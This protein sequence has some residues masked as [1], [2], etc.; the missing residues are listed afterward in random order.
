MKLLVMKPSAEKPIDR[1]WQAQLR[2]WRCLV[3]ACARKAGRR[4]VHALRVVTLRLLAYELEPR[5][6]ARK[7][8]VERLVQDWF[9]ETTRIRRA[10]GDVR[11]LD[12]FRACAANL[13]AGLE[14]PDA[15]HHPVSRA[16]LR[17]LNKLDEKLRERR[18][19][20]G[21]RLAYWI[22]KKQAHLMEL[23][24][25]M[26]A[27]MCVA[28]QMDAEGSLAAEVAALVEDSA[29]LDASS[30]HALRKRVKRIRYI[31]EAAGRDRPAARRILQIVRSVQTA[32]GTW[33]DWDALS[34]EARRIISGRQAKEFLFPLLD[35]LT[36][37]RLKQAIESCERMQFRLRELVRDVDQQPLHS[38]G[39]KMPVRRVEANS[40][41]TG[42][43]GA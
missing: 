9:R 21:K 28:P 38:T 23:S 2:N 37:E 6:S 15:S 8:F 39:R 7:T 24:L 31:M 26:E 34:K 19:K 30:L 36:A 42:A 16:T 13:R 35:E 27:S 32:V 20:A 5:D 10:L 40:S 3:E 29:S 25:E 4:Q 12:V 14:M 11:E 17:S 43:Q 18:R 22:A 1:I 41:G 33:H